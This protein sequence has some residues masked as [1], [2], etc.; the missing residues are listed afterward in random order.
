MD[1]RIRQVIENYTE[2]L[3]E[4]TQHH[5]GCA[6]SEFATLGFFC[7]RW[8]FNAEL[9]V[10]ALPRQGFRRSAVQVPIQLGL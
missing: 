1:E 3:A 10:A 9:G 6:G 7:C 8:R 4:R 2:K 5:L